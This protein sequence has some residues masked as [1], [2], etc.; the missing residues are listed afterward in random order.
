MKRI[1]AMAA[2]T[3]AGAAV[4]AG[5]FSDGELTR[6]RPTGW[7]RTRLETQLSGLS[8]HPEAMSYPYDTC[9][10]AGRIPRMSDHGLEAWRY[11]QTA[12]YTDGLLRLGYA[13]GDRKSIDKAEA[14]VRYTLA[15]QT[16]DG[17]LGDEKIHFHRDDA[18][19]AKE[20]QVGGD[21]WP[22]AVFFRAMKAYA[23]AHGKE[24]E[25]AA[26]LAKYYLGYAAEHLAVKDRNA[27][28]IE[29]MLWAAEKSGDRRLVE[30]AER[31]YALCRAQPEH[32]LRGVVDDRTVFLHGVTWCEN[33]KLPAMLYAHTGKRE[34][35]EDALRYQSKLE[36]DHM[37]PDGVPS[38]AEYV[39]GN[40]VNWGH[41][42]CDVAD[43]S[44]ALGY[45][46]EAT[47]DGKWADRIES[48]VFNAGGGC[49]TPDFKALQYFSNPNQVIATSDSN[50]NDFFFGSTWMAYRPTHET[51]CCA[52][53]VHRIWP[54]YVSRMWLRGPRGAVVAAL[55]GP[56]AYSGRADGVDFTIDERTDY[57][58]DGTVEFAFSSAK[59]VRLDF[60]F[61]RPE[62]CERM[63]VFVNGTPLET[64]TAKGTFA[65]VKREFRGGD[66]VRLEMAMDPVLHEA[67][68]I[69][70]LSAKKDGI[71]AT[72][73]GSSTKSQGVYFTR[74]P[75]L[76]ALPV[77]GDWL[78][79]AVEH[80]NMRGKKSGNP[81]FKC[82]NVR[83]K[84]AW[85]YAIAGRT[86]KFAKGR[87]LVPARRIKWE[88]HENR[89]M[90]W[91]PEKVEPLSDRNEEIA[92]VPYGDTTLRVSVFPE[93]P[94]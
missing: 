71:F 74:G 35:L 34:Y 37:L 21:M 52:G 49:V 77:E 55:Y 10:W 78:E 64:V 11:E 86:A 36:R 28:S 85:N 45:F 4:A 29:G 9:L 16:A 5:V 17:L 54:N 60:R 40:N 73:E 82:W 26:A 13:L 93:L 88:L 33:L 31:T 76:Y 32:P 39:K 62:W 51:E 84:S 50:N 92:L 94:R 30:L 15:H 42:T 91:I 2:A 80:A 66:R 22:Q 1:V 58:Y 89:M 25:V 14:G 6:T 53:N 18:V 41:E 24:R 63:K 81:D 20:D 8:G 23:E 47:G 69:R 61:R 3:A 44:W 46:L 65:A 83:P 75:L 67:P 43:Y 48:A 56:S 27:I 79:D 59:P 57:P 7:L 68:P 12:Y 72:M 38:G 87:L 70:F 90:P 19:I